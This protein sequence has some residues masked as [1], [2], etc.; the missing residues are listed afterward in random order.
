MAVKA[1]CTSASRMTMNEMQSTNPKE[2]YF[3]VHHVRKL[4]DMK[5]GTYVS[6]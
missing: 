1:W 2:G 3:E 6:T 4:S 5:D